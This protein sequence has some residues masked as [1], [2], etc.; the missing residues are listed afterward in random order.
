MNIVDEKLN[1][2]GQ[3]FSVLGHLANNP[4]ELLGSTY[5]LSDNDFVQTFHKTLFNA[6]SN[7]AIES[8][9]QLNEITP[10]AVEQYLKPFPKYYKIWSVSSGAQY[11]ADAKES[12]KQF[13]F[14]HDYEI[15]KKFSVLR[16]YYNQ[17]I[18]I[19]DWFDYEEQDIN[20]INKMNKKIDSADVSDIVNYFTEKVINL[21]N[22]IN[23][24]NSDIVR[25]DAKDDIDNLLQRLSEAPVMGH[26]FMDGYYNT[27]F[28]GMQSGRFM[29]RSSQSGN[30]KTRSALRDM[31]NISFSERYN[32]G[33]GW[34]ETNNA[35]IPTLFIST[36]LN[37]DEL[38]TILLAYVSGFTTA[39][40][41]EGNF[42]RYQ[43]DRL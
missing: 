11:L 27:L 32:I 23:E 1:P 14:N 2:A 30:G 9:G 34:E 16:Q 28:R 37:K 29:L 4:S 43:M 13:I 17:G 22:D 41:E 33:K 38:Q 24:N 42:T 40:I 31:A 26:P 18:D 20:I 19:K 36:E 7:I 12:E 39:E 21:R 15:V 8:N 35:T 6:I 3:V 5:K 10:V 25:F